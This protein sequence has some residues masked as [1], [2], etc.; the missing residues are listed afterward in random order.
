MKANSPRDRTK[1]AIG[2]RARND[3]N[4]GEA[5]ED[6]EVGLATMKENSVH[7][8][9]YQDW[10]TLPVE[11]LVERGILGMLKQLELR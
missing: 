8:E 10:T 1:K 6:T 5:V 4:P 2:Q 11:T 9:D 3:G 7:S